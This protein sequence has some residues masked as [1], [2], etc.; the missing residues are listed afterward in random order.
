M[1]KKNNLTKKKFNCQNKAWNVTD[2]HKSYNVL[3]MTL[4]CFC[5]R[6]LGS[7]ESPLLPLHLDPLWP[8]VIVPVRILS[9]EK[10]DPCEIISIR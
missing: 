10:I 6:A 2:I 5:S 4:N 1:L 3:A 7:K 8:G 9:M